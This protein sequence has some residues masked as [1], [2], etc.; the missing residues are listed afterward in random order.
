MN[1]TNIYNFYNYSIIYIRKD[2]IMK[3]KI[4]VLMLCLVAVFT[5]TA[6][7]KKED[8]KEEK[9]Y[10]IK[11]NANNQIYST[12]ISSYVTEVMILVNTQKISAFKTDTLYLV[13]VGNDLANSCNSEATPGV[14]WTYAYVGVVYNGEKYTY[15]FTGKDD[16]G[17]GFDLIGYDN[18]NTDALKYLKDKVVPPIELEF[19]YGAERDFCVGTEGGACPTGWGSEELINYISNIGNKNIKHLKFIGA[20]EC[21]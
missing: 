4:L 15:Y 9:K 17:K 21:K 5:L 11:D 10:S 16:K 6:C 18:L 19:I 13:P 2:E 12:V 7:D 20:N 3:K 8:S 1:I 14:K